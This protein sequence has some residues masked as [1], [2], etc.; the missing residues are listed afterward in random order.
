MSVHNG[1]RY[2]RAQIDSLFAQSYRNWR[3]I[4][5]DDNSSDGSAAILAG[6]KDKYPEKIQIVTDADG[7][8]GACQGFGRVLQAAEAEYM[9]FCD[10]DDV[11]M[12]GKIEASLNELKRL[13]TR[14]PETPTLVYTDLAV[15]D[16]NL[17]LIS[18]SF[19]HYQRIK[20][21]DNSLP[22]LILDNVATGCT[23]IFNRHLKNCAI[24]L[25]R[26]AVMHDWWLALVCSLY[27]KMGF[28]N[29]K[30]ALYRQHGRNDT[31]AEDFSFKTRAQRFWKSPKGVFKRSTEKA[32][33][34]RL[35]AEKLLEL[36]GRLPASSPEAISPLNDF[37]ASRTFFARKWCLIRHGMLSGNYIKAV[38]KLLF[39]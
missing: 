7:Q 8:L 3:L 36:T 15:V 19:W 27:G 4:V 5:R 25:P 22:L 17:T 34:V 30:T 14:H 39:F 35:Q 29:D 6:Y 26:E 31:G 37:V 12:P 9:M 11:W 20:P 32:A 21:G 1:E 16:E 10:Q 18:D 28:V 13:E 38:K 24:P 2:L 23:M 33:L